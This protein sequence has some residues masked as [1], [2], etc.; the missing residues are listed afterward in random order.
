[1]NLQQ[2]TPAMNSRPQHNEKTAINKKTEETK[3]V[4]VNS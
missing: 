4:V 3:Y 1:M 2:K